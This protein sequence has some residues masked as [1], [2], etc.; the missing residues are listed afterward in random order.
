MMYLGL[1]IFLLFKIFQVSTHKS[2]CDINKN[3]RFDCFPESGVTEESCYSRGCCWDN[4]NN[5]GQP[6]C[7]YG[8]ANIGYNVCGYKETIT[9]FT[10]E[11][12]LTGLG[13]HY[14][15]NVL[16]L[17]ANFYLETDNTLHVKIFDPYNKRYEVPT[18]SPNV[19][20]KA[21]S[22]NYHV[23]YT[24]DLFSFKVVRISNGEV[25]FDSNVGGFIFSDQFIQISSILPSDNIYGLGEHVLGLK[26]STDWNLLTLF[27]RDI[28]T[29]EG[30]VNLYGVHPFY[31]NIEKTGLAN[32]VFLKNSN[33]MDIILQPTP[34]ITYRTIGGIL[35]FYIFL[36]PTVNDVVSQYTKIVGRPIMP[37]YWSLGFHLCRWGYNS[38]NEMN[39]V[40][41]RMAANQIP[42]DVQW[43]DIDY[44]D[45]FRDFTIGYSFKG[46]NRFVDNLHDQGMH[47]VIM[48]D[49]ALSI[50]YHGYLPYDEGIKENI[51]IKNSKGE[52]LVGAV[53]P[54]LAA[55]PDFTHPNISNYWLMQI[56]S[57]HEKLQ[58]DGLW[59]D[60]NEPS[61][62]VDGSSKGC[63]KN[64]YDQPPYTPA[65][66]GGTLFQKTLCMNSQ[67]YGGSHYNLHSLYGH[68][69]SKVTM[70][71]LQKIRGKRSFVISRSTYS[72]TGVYAGHWLGDNHSTWEDLYKSIAGIINFNLFGIP[73]VGADICGFSGDTTEELCSRWMQLGAFYP[74]SRNHNDHESRSQDPAAFGE[75]LIIA[76]RNALNTRYQL[77]PY[78][79]SLFFEAYVNGTP[80][81]RGLFS[82][83]PTD[84]NCLNNDKQFMWGKGLLISPVIL[85]GA[86]NVRAYLPAGF[87][88]NFYTGELFDSQGEYVNLPASYEYVNLH[89]R[90]GVIIP[91]QDS[92][93]TT[94][95]SR[96]NDFGMIVALNNDGKANGFLYLDDGEQILEENLEKSSIIEFHSH[97]GEFYSI[98]LY[99]KFFPN[100]TTFSKI[101][102]YGVIVEPTQVNVNGK[103]FLFKYDKN[104]KVLG[105]SDMGLSILEEN[106]IKWSA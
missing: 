32:G 81:A 72:G 15:K 12:C 39:A 48:L 75:M 36:G 84:S 24:N 94:T 66:I 9:G 47:Y 31:V 38:L 60:M 30:G 13:G 8:S 86:V 91:T 80:V 93:I 33:A 96:E 44:M 102:I 104:L 3:L 52:V 11:L 7:Y 89:I 34:A 16:K 18:P 73:L 90:G 10:L 26:L 46:L 49:P 23:T 22:L 62:F 68:L 40:R 64:A 99:N 50:N 85:E 28:P 63:P 69:E 54:G 77:L 78:L 79:Y 20:N 41:N 43:N 83:F 55:F 98:P 61:S 74:F 76:S 56:K 95:K 2:I 14:G 82:E 97:Q 4:S 1:G 87:W 101:S 53:W 57:F 35:D 103:A 45:N 6:I 58:F 88:F 21:T 27:S 71:S 19:K 37:P 105:I 100:H 17:N 70:S 59:I 65:I 67:Q 42:Q 5:E 92:A 25:I 29:P 51:F 106:H